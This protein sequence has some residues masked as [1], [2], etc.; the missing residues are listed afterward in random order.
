MVEHRWTSR[1][2][3][4]LA[5]ITLVAGCATGT[6]TPGPSLST[7]PSG[8]LVSPSATPA[9][10]P[11]TGTAAPPAASPSSSPAVANEWPFVR[12]AC[13]GADSQPLLLVAL[14]TS[15]TSGYG[16]RPDEPYSPQDAYPAQYADILCKELGATV[17]LHSYFPSPLSSTL[18][19]LAWWNERVAADPAIRADLAAAKIVVLWAMS[20]HDVVPAL[21]VGQCSGDW[22]DPLKACFESATAEIP[23]Q[24][25]RL[26]TA[27]SELVPE[28]AKILAGDAY[29]LPAINE[30]WAA[31]PY[32]KELKTMVDPKTTV[33]PLARKHGFTFVDVEAAFD[34]LTGRAA[35]GLFQSDGIHPTTA[36][37]LAVAKVFAGADGLG[38]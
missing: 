9:P 35:E 4:G 31:K 5:T 13:P 37:A 15:E 6:T 38:R 23:A 30:R 29:A 1:L 11:P 19:P 7:S 22:P 10:T 25:E 18:S 17:E 8:A 34:A 27:I 28:G 24:T 14:G 32:W 33:M 21:V 36:G 2:L 26:F 3:A 12:S 16:I 20:S